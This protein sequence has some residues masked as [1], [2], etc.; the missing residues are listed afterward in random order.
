MKVALAQIC[1]TDD[2]AANLEQVAAR[3]A[4][5]AARGAELVVF[6]EATMC[7]FGHPLGGIAEPLDG[8]F[9]R[10]VEQLGREHDIHV[11]LGMFTPSQDGSRVRNTL[12]MAGPSGRFGYDKI[13]LYD[14]FGFQESRTVEPGSEPVCFPLGSTRLGAA[15]CYDV[16]FSQLFVHN[17]RAGATVQLVCASWGAGPGKVEQWQLVCR[18]RAV[19]STCFVLACGQAEPA[20]SGVDAVE[21]APTGVGHSMVVS[22]LGEV[23]AEAGE[24]PELLVAEIDLG[25]V[26]Q[27]RQ[28]L[29]VLANARLS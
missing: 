22:P 24:A 16:R 2:V 21:G 11:V 28:T 3:V 14:A 12:L 20:A 15:I 25:E 6:P 5:A 9:A 7:A 23:L 27:V 4:E 18:A 1:T 8:G 19:D 10:R 26:E 17:A 13:H 29:P